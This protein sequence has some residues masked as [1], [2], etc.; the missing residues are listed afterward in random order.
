MSLYVKGG[1]GRSDEEVIETASLVWWCCL[2]GTLCLAA[3][4]AKSEE[5]EEALLPVISCA[6]WEVQARGK[7]WTR[8]KIVWVDDA[9]A[10]QA[11]DRCPKR[12]GCTVVSFYNPTTNTI[13]L[14]RSRSGAD[15]DADLAH[16]LAHAWM[17]YGGSDEDEARCEAFARRV[18]ALVANEQSH[19]PRMKGR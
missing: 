8:V 6:R 4:F 18:L 13:Y 3:G 7:S 9:K 12:E 19:R 14:C 10:L 11:V 17:G 1:Q 15:V 16:E 5:Y 2:V